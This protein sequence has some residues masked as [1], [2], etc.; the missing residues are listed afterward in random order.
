MARRRNQLNTGTSFL[1]IVAAGKGGVGKTTL[2]TLIADQAALAEHPIAPFQVD[3]QRRLGE[4]LG[5]R[6]H[7]IV[8][9]YEAAM[10]SPRAL[11]SPFAPLYN[12]CAAA[13]QGG[14]SPMVDIGPNHV[15]LST[16]WMRKSEL[17]ED[18]DAWG[19]QACGLRSGAGRD[20]VAAP[21]D[22]DNPALRSRPA[23]RHARLRRE[24]ARRALRRPQVP[25]RAR[26]SSSGTN[27]CRLSATGTT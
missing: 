9:D 6:V 22:R 10:R 19:C 27:S 25:A 15:E 16:M 7:T 12:A 13:G 26:P 3:D 14:P 17:G 23:G 24:P 4:M 18:L 5:E 11:T 1:A 20:R 8:P 2:A 21:G